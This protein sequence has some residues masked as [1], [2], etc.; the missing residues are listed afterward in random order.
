MKPIKVELE[1]GAILAVILVLDMDAT[2]DGIRKQIQEEVSELVPED[3]HFISSWG[4]P[5]SRV[6]ECKIT[7]NEAPQDEKLVIWENVDE[8]SSLKRKAAD[9]DE[10]ETTAQHQVVSE[11]YNQRLLKY[12]VRKVHQQ[13][14]TLLGQLEKECT[15]FSNKT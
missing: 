8:R 5:I 13:L 12:L 11:P 7:L 9:I 4:S 10:S 14:A 3:F 6:Q 1:S 2:L 15:S